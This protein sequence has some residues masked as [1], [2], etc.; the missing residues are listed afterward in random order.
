M[1]T[2]LTDLVGS[3]RIIRHSKEIGRAKSLSTLLDIHQPDRVVATLPIDM[4]ELLTEELFTR[5]MKPM[6]RPVY[7]HRRTAGEFVFRGY[8][9]VLEIRVRTRPA[10]KELP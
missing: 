2:A 6:L 5:G 4:Q 1:D 8:E 9:E 3:H 7:H 10:T